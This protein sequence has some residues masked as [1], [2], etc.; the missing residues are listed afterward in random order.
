M[1]HM[2]RPRLQQVEPLADYK[3]KL[4]FRNNAV[5]TVDFIPFFAENPGLIRLRDA[6]EFAKAVVDEWGW[7]VE[8]LDL[9]IQIGADTLWMDAQAQNAPDENTRFFAGWRA[10]YGLSLKQ[11]AEAIGVTPRTI[12]AY[13]SGARPI[14]KTVKLA[15]IGW[16]AL[17]KA[18]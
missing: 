4:V 16:E 7:T 17:K 11:A 1:A 6:A 10:R 12:S 5:F 14:P 3:M 2:T 18:A 13:S 9:D 15:C 8:W